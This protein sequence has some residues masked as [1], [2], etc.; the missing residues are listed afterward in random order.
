[1]R[2]TWPW[3]LLL[4]PLALLA[5]RGR[6]FKSVAIS[7]LREWRMVGETA[8]IRWLRRM[9]W[10]ELASCLLLILALAGPV[11]Q[12]SVLEEVRHG[13]AIEM[14]IDISSSMDCAITGAGEKK[15]NR[16]DAAKTAVQEFIGVRTDDLIGL[17]KFARYADTVCPLTFGHKALQQLA[18]E[19]KIQDRPNEDGTAYGDA[20]MQACAQLQQMSEWRGTGRRDIDR[21]RSRIIVL[22][23]DG[24]NNCGR[25][26]PQEAA[27]LAEKWGIRIYVVSL[28]ESDESGRLSDAD[29]LLSSVAER[30][31]GSFWKID[32]QEGLESAY[33][34]IDALEK[35]D[36]SDTTVQHEE[37]V[38]VF[39]WFL[40]PALALITLE[41]VLNATLLRVNQEETA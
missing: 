18:G 33:A 16:M 30:S 26:L 4:L 29:Q 32:D 13:I 38:H 14:L 36:I 6:S 10:L 17:I 19:L 35:S 34:Q 24:E 9:R 15:Q 2:F 12:R 40:L 11:L 39:A 31:G 28:G 3:V 20:L 41:L 22:L 23:T 5:L 21:I 25:H 27:A 1:M 8:R 37:P 7:S